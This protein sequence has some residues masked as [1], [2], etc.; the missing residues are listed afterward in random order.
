MLPAD[1][2]WVVDLALNYQADKN[3]KLFATVNNLFNKSLSVT[4]T[5]E[6]ETAIEPDHDFKNCLQIVI[7]SKRKCM[8]FSF[9]LC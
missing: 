5:V 2:Y 8:A 1:D 7:E 3:I 9:L 4:E 6:I